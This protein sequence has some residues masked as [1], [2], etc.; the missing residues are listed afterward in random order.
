MT[1]RSL[2]ILLLLFVGILV[3]CNK[4]EDDK[5]STTIK[6]VFESERQEIS[7]GDSITF[8][9]FSEGYATK[10]KWTFEGGTPATSNL[11]S[12]VVK[13]NTPG[14]YSVT[15]EVSNGTTTTT[16]TKKDYI[17]VDYN[18]VKA[19]FNTPSQVVFTSQTISF[20]DSSAGKPQTWL[21]EFVPVSGGTKL[22]S[23]QQNPSM[24]FTD[25]GYYNVSLTASNPSYSD[26]K[27]KTNFIRVIDIN[28]VSADFISNETA[29]YEGGSI[30][31]SDRS[32]GFVTSWQWNIE[33]PV[34]LTS[35]Q[36]N[37]VFNFTTAGRYK[38]SLTVSN[39]TK[40]TAKTLNNYVLVVPSGSLGAFFPFN[41]NIHDVGPNAISTTSLGAGVSFTNTDRNGQPGNTATFNGATGII[42]ANHSACNFGTS[43]F[44]ISCWVKTS[45]S[46]KMMVWQESG[47]NAGGDNQTWLRLGD[48]TTD[49]VI[50][51][52]VEDATGS[53]ILNIPSTSKVSDGVWH[54]VVAVRQ[55][56]VISVY[57]DGV[58]K[59]TLTAS[60]L[61]VVSNNEDFKIGVQEG[62]TSN[63]SFFNGDIDDFI[64]YNKALS[65]AE[66]L[67][68]Y[69]L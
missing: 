65:D 55:G 38:V 13:Y 46:S 44:S 26:K 61:K 62:A 50:R 1:M 20:K 40:T 10:W 16:L 52:D 9:D 43:D 35:T 11:S 4:P 25:T 53:A 47:K 39:G 17:K 15:V 68:L 29:T 56:L 19:D 12:P 36:Q 6:P 48:N 37:P 27:T 8:K 7:A 54:H 24:T 3:S 51:L 59:G 57:I 31:F 49:R 66:I 64:I 32:L 58:K 30:S 14:S 45:L 28:A 21:W 5:T 41:G 22:T 23:T 69:N 33:G 67:A 63:S 34:T 2:P 18:Q 42:V 60:G